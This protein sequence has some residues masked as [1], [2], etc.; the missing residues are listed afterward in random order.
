M[1]NIIPENKT[2]ATREPIIISI[3]S[4]PPI[5]QSILDFDYIIGRT[6]PTVKAIIGSG[7]KLER[8][9]FGRKEVAIPVCNDSQLKDE[10][11]KLKNEP[12][13]YLNVNSGRRALSSITA[14]FKTLDEVKLST[15][16]VG[17]VI[18][19]ENLPEAHAIELINEA[20]KRH[21]WIIGP[22]SIGLFIP[23]Y[24][25][26]GAI[27]GVDHRQLL[28]AKA[29]EQGNVAVLSASGGM[30]NELIWNVA[31]SEKALSFAL[32]FGGDR[33]PILS[34]TEA[35]IAA[36]NDVQTSHIVY[37]GELGGIDE[38]EIIDLIQQQKLTKPVYAYIAGSVSDL[39]AEP[40]QFG[41]AKAIAKT[42]DESANAKR[43]AL[44]KA[45]VHAAKTFSEF[46]ETVRKIPAISDKKISLKKKSTSTREKNDIMVLM[47]DRRKSLFMSSV[48]READ[49]S[50]E[51]L[52][53]PLTT[54]AK[55]SSLAHIVLSSFLGKE[56]NSSV[57]VDFIDT[58]FKLLIDNGPAVSGAVNTII[59]ARAG[60]DLPSALAS[61][62]L[63][64]GPRF[65]GAIKDA[66]NN[67]Y[68]CVQTNKTPQE[69]VEEFASQKT[70]I[71]GIGHKKYRTDNPDPRCALLVE[72]AMQLK[73][74]P[75]Y[76][77]A[78]H[79]EKITTA[80]KAN[81]ILNVDGTV[82][83]IMLDILMYEEKL[84]K[85]ALQNLLATDFFNALFIFPRTAGFIA[86]CL[87][88]QRLDEGLFRLP[89]SEILYTGDQ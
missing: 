83:A 6:S 84:T 40:P 85:T 12:I 18:F 86:H 41:H 2:L 65:G 29:D 8:Y 36:E 30:T 55:T 45:G 27:A 81:L 72:H 15:Q 22:S 89:S 73:N 54:R 24:I 9:F 43:Q 60:R 4:H 58:V 76:D 28:Q 59:T 68:H 44:R 75:H 35:F 64:I 49:G 11:V 63:T 10:L 1:L 87:D 47:S 21:T 51:I 67:W 7:R 16:L 50:V 17:G 74:H 53:K 56:V 33:F 70:Y 13:Y 32:S 34:P 66:S 42:T 62:I 39:F 52:G 57:T 79:V 3:G 19:A 88:Q 31:Y 25:K 69:F 26:L 38:Y 78:Q 23:N 80:K 71:P 20:K 37:Y 14:F 61:G 82:A 46:L 48:S 5:I 77:F